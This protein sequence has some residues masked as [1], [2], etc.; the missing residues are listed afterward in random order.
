[1]KNKAIYRL[2]SVVAFA[3]ISDQIVKYLVETG[4]DY[5]QQIDILPFLALFRVHNNGIAF[6]MLSG[7]HDLVLIGL[8]IVVVGFVSYLWWS[9]ASSRWISRFGFALIIGGAV[10]NLIDRSLHGYVIDYILFHL[11]S[12]SFAVFNLADAYISIGAALVV[13]EEILTWLRDR[14]ARS[15]EPGEN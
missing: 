12:W 1:M 13:L 9:T 10:G 6:S 2:F 14:R 3:V 11:P 8:T 15:G 5:Q 7:L 4:M